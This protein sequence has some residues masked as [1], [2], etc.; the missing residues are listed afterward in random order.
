MSDLT[1]EELSTL[2]EE[3]GR[4][5]QHFLPEK[6]DKA[7]AEIRT[8]IQDACNNG[9]ALVIS[10]RLYC[11]GPYRKLFEGLEYTM[12][13]KGLAH[14]ML[15]QWLKTGIADTV[16]ILAQPLADAARGTKHN[17]ETAKC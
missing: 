3:H 11:S 1:H 2:I 14:P 8:M 5:L 9:T 10:N 12:R 7:V 17:Q 6:R 13:E 15:T 4:D 16:S